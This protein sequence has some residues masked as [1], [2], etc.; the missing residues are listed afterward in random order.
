MT[1]GQVI[2]KGYRWYLDAGIGDA[3]N[4]NTAQTISVNNMQCYGMVSTT[5]GY[6]YGCWFV[7]A[8]IGYYHSFRDKENIYPLY[9]AGRYSLE[10]VKLRP[11]METRAGIV[12]DPY[13]ISPVQAYGA[14]G[15]GLNVYRRFQTGLRISVFSRPSRYFTANAAIVFCYEFGK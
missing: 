13:W 2:E 6:R 14:F 7:G 5:H 12:F 8:G 4:F 1:K 11:Y 3:Y 9:L 10:D 15:V